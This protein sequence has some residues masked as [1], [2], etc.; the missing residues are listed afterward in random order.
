[1]LRN[2][3]EKR[4]RGEHM[5]RLS[6]NFLRSGQEER[7]VLGHIRDLVVNNCM[8][9]TDNLPCSVLELMD[10]ESSLYVEMLER[11]F[12]KAFFDKPY[13][14]WDK[15]SERF[16][17]ELGLSLSFH[18]YSPE[19]Y[20]AAYGKDSVETYLYVWGYGMDD[21]DALE[22]IVGDMSFVRLT[23][24]GDGFSEQLCERLLRVPDSDDSTITGHRFDM[25]GRYV[26][27]CFSLF[28]TNQNGY[29]ICYSD[30]ETA[31]LLFMF[32]DFDVLY[33]YA[34]Q[35]GRRRRNGRVS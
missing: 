21:S 31:W 30:H 15:L 3:Q 27:I 19:E 8:Y 26:E 16:F 4:K 17:G 28:P 25:N 1:M 13:K 24:Q 22:S 14:S 5:A 11:V 29:Q 10:L 2:L 6:N 7:K 34:K 23:F 33:E 12:G 32:L 35:F 20:L 18:S 9:W